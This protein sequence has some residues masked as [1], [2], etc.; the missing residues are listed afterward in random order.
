MGIASIVQLEPLS[1]PTIGKDYHR[2]Y[3]PLRFEVITDSDITNWP[4]VLA[5][6]PISIF[7]PHPDD[8]NAR[9]INITPKRDENHPRYWIVE[10]DYSTKIELSQD[11]QPQTQQNPLERKGRI[12]FSG[13]RYQE[14]IIRDQLGRPICNRANDPYETMADKVLTAIQIQRNLPFGVPFGAI[15]AFNT[16]D[17]AE[18]MGAINNQPFLGFQASEVLCDDLVAEPKQEAHGPP[19]WE[20]NA[21]FVIKPIRQIAPMTGVNAGDEGGWF[22]RKL[23]A[24][25]RE[26]IEGEWV[27]IF[28]NG[29]RPSRPV[30]L[31]M[32]GRKLAPGTPSQ[33]AAP[34]F[35][36]F[37]TYPEVNFNDLGLLT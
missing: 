4:E 28:E 29:Q 16:V 8:S 21:L 9:C 11:G 19:F 35:L 5:A 6:I 3:S 24:G 30:L 25:Y 26:L 2:E 37:N 20:V 15:P 10:Y 33:P 34:F 13:R 22:T 32:N 27:P 18:Y 36:K 31:D 12:V 7:T 1:V 17:I 14:A 23:N